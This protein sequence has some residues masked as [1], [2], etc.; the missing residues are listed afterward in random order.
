M[1]AVERKGTHELDVEVGLGERARRGLANCCESLGKHVIQGLARRQTLA[2]ALRRPGDL[3][4]ALRGSPFLQSVDALD[5][6][7]QALELCLVLVEEAEEL[8]DRPRPLLGDLQGQLQPRRIEE[9]AD[10]LA[11]MDTADRLGEE[12]GDR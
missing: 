1:P 5:L 11:V 9:C 4:G 2:E 12:R 6:L 10:G 3:L 8:R 7:A